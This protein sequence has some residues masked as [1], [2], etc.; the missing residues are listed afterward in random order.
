MS[1]ELAPLR[2][3]DLKTGSTTVDYERLMQEALT[4]PGRLGSTYTRF[5]PYSFGNQVALFMQ[6]AEGPV[7]TYDRWQAMGRQ[8]KRG[9]KAKSIL[10]PLM[11]KRTDDEGNEEMYARGFKWVRCIFQLSD[12][13]G[14]ELPPWEPPEWS[15][16]R[17]LGALG[18]REVAFQMLDGNIQGYSSG[19]ELAINPVAAYPMKTLI[20]ELGHIVLGHTAP[21]AHDEYQSH[22]GLKEFQA[23]STAYLGMNELGALDRMDASESRGYIQHWLSGREP[24]E[25]DIR[26]VFTA[27]DKIL[28]AGRPALVTDVGAKL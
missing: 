24:T 26:Q 11:G 21:D 10:R 18:I 2:A 19:H 22:R 6:G 9:S 12:T 17:A 28:K 1:A 20:H 8:V 3:D 15:R 23:E 13:E 25:R 27:T 14:E 5:Y 16:E 7:N 4:M